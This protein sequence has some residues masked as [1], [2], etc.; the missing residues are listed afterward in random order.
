MFFSNNLLLLHDCTIRDYYIVL[1]VAQEIAL[2]VHLRLPGVARRVLAE[3]LQ[4]AEVVIQ[5]D[6]RI[7]LRAG[8][9]GLVARA[10]ARNFVFY[11][12]HVIHRFRQHI[13]AIITQLAAHNRD[14]QQGASVTKI[15]KA[16]V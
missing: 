10:H 6:A 12:D 13:N 8:V 14:L 11:G 15:T 3:D 16:S 5:V 2:V 4:L 9:V 7:R 1:A